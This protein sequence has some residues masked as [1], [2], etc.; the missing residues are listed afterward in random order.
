MNNS[1]RGS[2]LQLL[3]VTVSP[4]R[5]SSPHPVIPLALAGEGA[6]Q[7]AVGPL[8]VLLLCTGNSSVMA[9]RVLT[10]LSAKHTICCLF[11]RPFVCCN[12]EKSEENST[13]TGC[14]AKLFP[15]GYW[16]FCWLL[17]MQIAKV[18]PFLK[19]SENLLHDLIHFPSFIPLLLTVRYKCCG[20]QPPATSHQRSHC[21]G[22]QEDGDTAHLSLQFSNFD[23]DV[24]HHSQ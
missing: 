9:M 23:I 13:L 16:L 12:I 19:N 3:S 1:W 18:G 14:P 6:C 17:L 10:F 7:P 2:R 11:V 22:R 15:L 4:A 20:V 8:P 21:G 24:H 5:C